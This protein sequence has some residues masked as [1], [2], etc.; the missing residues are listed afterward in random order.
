MAPKVLL[1]GFSLEATELV[2][3][4]G[5][6]LG[7]AGLVDDVVNASGHRLLTAETEVAFIEHHK[8]DF[9]R[10]SLFL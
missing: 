8:S 9:P 3:I 6:T 5:R 4:K 7:F 2:V 1:K 10:R